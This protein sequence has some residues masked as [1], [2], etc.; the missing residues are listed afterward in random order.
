MKKNKT[1]S[2]L[3]INGASIPKL[4]NCATSQH[5]IQRRPKTQLQQSRSTHC[6]R[7][8][9]SS[10]LPAPNPK[11]PNPQKKTLPPK[12]RLQPCGRTCSVCKQSSEER[13]VGTERNTRRQHDV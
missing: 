9:T 6:H 7:L 13:R 4:V 12:M 11:K 3:L 1:R 10:M 8:K 5:R 2:V